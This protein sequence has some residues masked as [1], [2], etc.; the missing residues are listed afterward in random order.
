MKRN[1]SVLQFQRRLIRCA[2]KS[3]TAEAYRLL[4]IVSSNLKETMPSS[5]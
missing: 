5:R 3:P 2:L 1:L 4:G